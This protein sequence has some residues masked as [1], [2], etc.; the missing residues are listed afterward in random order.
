[1]WLKLR[2]IILASVYASTCYCEWVPN[3]CEAWQKDGNTIS[4][5]YE[6]RPNGEDVFTVYCDMG[7]TP[8][9][10]HVHH[11]LTD[12]LTMTPFQMYAV[13]F[14]N[15]LWEAIEPYVK[16]LFIHVCISSETKKFEE[17]GFQFIHDG[18]VQTNFKD[19]END[20]ICDQNQYKFVKE[21]SSI[22]PGDVIISRSEIVAMV[23]PMVVVTVQGCG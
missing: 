11:N 7:H 6:I 22:H 8:A 18:D 13:G 16:Y 17:L 21:L 14:N 9:R 1:M 15:R 23:T 20:C 4:G 2:T 19:C 10:V 5:A 3:T 12:P